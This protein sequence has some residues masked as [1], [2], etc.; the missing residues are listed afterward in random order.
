MYN[1]IVLL[2][3]ISIST[4]AAIDEKKDT[5]I[6]VKDLKLKIHSAQRSIPLPGRVSAQ[7]K[8]DLRPEVSGYITKIFKPMGSKVNRGTAILAIRNPSGNYKDYI[9]KSPI[10]GYVQDLPVE[11]GKFI[12]E[13]DIAAKISDPTKLKITAQIPF[14]EKKYTHIGQSV[15]VIT[16]ENTIWTVKAISPYIGENTGTH[17]IEIAHKTK[18]K[19]SPGMFVELELLLPI[20]KGIAVP[21]QAIIEKNSKHYLRVIENMKV[22]LVEIQLKEKIGELQF[23]QSNLKESQSVVLYAAD[24]LKDGDKVKLK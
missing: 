1:F 19:L 5:E 10:S 9:L 18:S 20:T 8:F 12:S 22:K 23:I 14:E 3:A 6:L 13:Q 16:D 7:M 4:F 2:L 11:L 17:E 21:K 15:K 24:Y